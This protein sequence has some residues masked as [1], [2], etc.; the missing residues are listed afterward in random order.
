MQAGRDKGRKW[1]PGSLRA[2]TSGQTTYPPRTT[3]A[4]SPSNSILSNHEIFNFCADEAHFAWGKSHS[5]KPVSTTGFCFEKDERV[6]FFKHQNLLHGALSGATP[7]VLTDDIFWTVEVVKRASMQ[8]CSTLLM[9]HLV[10]PSLLNKK[11]PSDQ[12]PHRR[13]FTCLATL[14]EANDCI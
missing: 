12:S 3:T 7:R 13:R 4:T 10:V 5:R 11:D 8:Y 2:A 9:E 6:T 1:Q 14:G